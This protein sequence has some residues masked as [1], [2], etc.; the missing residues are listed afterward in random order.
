MCY[1]GIDKAIEDPSVCL[2]ALPAVLVAPIIY[3]FELARGIA[4]VGQRAFRGLGRPHRSYP[5][6][7]FWEVETPCAP[8]VDRRHSGQRSRNDSNQ[9][10]FLRVTR[11]SLGA[12]AKRQTTAGTTWRKTSRRDF[13]PA[14]RRNR[15]QFSGQRFGT[16]AKRDLGGEGALGHAFGTGFSVRWK[17][18]F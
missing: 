2:R 15:A 14:K 8:R 5:E 11:D 17:P 4:G 9:E 6:T 16:G 7:G 3:P 18:R 12:A 13:R 10:T 1:L